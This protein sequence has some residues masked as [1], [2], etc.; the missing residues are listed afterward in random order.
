MRCT[1][2]DKYLVLFHSKTEQ[3]VHQTRENL[4]HEKLNKTLN[5]GASD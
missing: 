5:L 4:E 2:G 1:L 3:I